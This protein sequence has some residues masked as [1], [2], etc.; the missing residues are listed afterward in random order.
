MIHQIIKNDICNYLMG[1]DCEGSVL[2]DFSECPVFALS[3]YGYWN[4]PCFWVYYRDWQYCILPNDGLVAYQTAYC[5]TWIA[6]VDQ[7]REMETFCIG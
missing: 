1:I 7:M 2:F 5:E 3:V 6:N 4:V